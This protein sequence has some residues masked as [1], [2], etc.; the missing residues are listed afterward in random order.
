V[1]GPV[2]GAAFLECLST[3]LWGSFLKVHLLIL[4]VLITAVVMLLPDGLAPALRR[5]PRRGRAGA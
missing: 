3:F 5:L 4:G 2:I 1:L